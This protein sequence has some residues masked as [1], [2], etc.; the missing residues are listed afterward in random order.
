M[1]KL[2]R[3]KFLK[4]AT[5]TAGSAAAMSLMG[6]TAFAQ[7]TRIRHFWWGNPSRDE[8]T[9]KVIE[10]FKA[11]NPGVDVVG[12]TVG[13]GDYWTKM[14]TQTAGKNMADLVQMDYRFL[15]EYVRRGALLPLDDYFGKTLHLDGFDESALAGGMVD[16]KLYALNIGSNS[17]V[18]I[19][20]TRM[21]QEAGADAEF[22]PIMWNHADQMR[23]GKAIT[24]STPDGVYG[25]DDISLQAVS[26]ELWSRQ[27]GRNFYDGDK[28]NGKAEDLI[29][30]WKFWKEMRDAGACPPAD[31]TVGLLG[32]NMADSGIVTQNTAMSYMWSNQIV[33]VQSLSTDTVGAAMHAHKDGGEPGQ[34]IK[35]SMFMCL[36]RDTSNA[37]VATAYMNAW[38]ND[39]EATA[40]LGLERGIPASPE[41]RAALAPNFSEAEKVSVDYFTAI[42]DHV[43]TLPA[44]PPKGAGEAQDAYERVA[45][46]VILGTT[47]IEDGAAAFID[48]ASAIIDRAS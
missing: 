12:E 46:N 33:G 34:F 43:G 29:S 41:V 25:T 22:D 18:C 19:F 3:R 42:Q 45:T 28:V 23:V 11:A 2:N 47:S 14:A 38:V 9:F 6:T 30:F 5:A 24:A 27:N 20:N 39:P 32:S 35:P 31:V 8:R 37:D 15:F 36:T 13:W 1:T 44:P 21:V 26:W 48:E 7:D 40:I 17:Q 4:S 16:G 10:L